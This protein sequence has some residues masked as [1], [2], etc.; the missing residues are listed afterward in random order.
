MADVI[1]TAT[2]DAYGKA[3]VEPGHQTPCGRVLPAEHCADR[4]GYPGLGH[5]VLF[6]MGDLRHSRLI[7]KGI[8]GMLLYGSSG[9]GAVFM[10]AIAAVSR[11]DQCDPH[12]EAPCFL[13]K[14]FAP[15]L[16]GVFGGG[17]SGLEGDSQQSV[18]RGKVDDAAK[19]LRPHIR[20]HRAGHPCHAE[21]IG[22]HDGLQLVGT[23]FL[24]GT[25]GE[26]CRTVDQSVN[27]AFPFHNIVDG[28]A[29]RGV[30]QHVQID[31]FAADRC[32]DTLC[33]GACTGIGTEPLCRQMLRH[34]PSQAG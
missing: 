13:C 5:A 31:R 4:I 20:Q 30:I 24:A 23:G 34:G 2:R 8:G 10:G 33:K 16:D 3:L 27:A 12:T 26:E 21:K 29:C 6:I 28:R 11:F 9:G 7:P 19:F 22:L 17:I 1:K 32:A 18:D 14:A 15:A 25:E